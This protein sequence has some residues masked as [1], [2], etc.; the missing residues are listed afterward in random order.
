MLE[1][2]Y[3]Y[4]LRPAEAKELT[5]GEMAAFIKAQ[6]KRDLDF[7]KTLANVGYSTGML[8]SMSLS[9][10]RPKFGDMFQFPKETPDIDRL[11]KYKL[12]MMAWAEQ[13]NRLTR[14]KKRG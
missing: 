12:Q 8:A 4:G 10:K 11:D 9:K 1:E 7:T 14:R 3:Y 5:L 6:R 13:S 2:L